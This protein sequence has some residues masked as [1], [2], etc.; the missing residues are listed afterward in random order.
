MAGDGKSQAEARGSAG[1]AVRGLLE[2]PEDSLAVLRRHAES[3]VR[4]GHHPL[5]AVASGVDQHLVTAV[6]LG[7]LQEVAEDLLDP[8]RVGVHPNLATDRHRSGAVATRGEDEV[9]DPEGR[10]LQREVGGLHQELAGLETGNGQHVLDDVGQ[11][12]GFAHD[13]P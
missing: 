1:I 13:D 10:G 7:V 11:M 3:V 6:L 8:I 5:V 9:G 2:D 4:H 12:F